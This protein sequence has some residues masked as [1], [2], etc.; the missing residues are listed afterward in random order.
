VFKVTN[1]IYQ[2]IPK[3]DSIPI[4]MKFIRLLPIILI[5]LTQACQTSSEKL[6]KENDLL[7]E[8]PKKKVSIAEIEEGIKAY[9]DEE[10]KQN[11]GYFLVKGK[12]KSLD[13]NWCGSTLNT[14]PI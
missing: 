4:F 11:E 12:K 7:G 3:I 14:S 8:T 9:I 10:T 1:Y 13:L 5:V 2:L 6:N